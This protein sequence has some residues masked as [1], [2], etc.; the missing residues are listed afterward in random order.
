MQIKLENIGKSFGKNDV[1]KGLDLTIN[2]GELISLVGP[3]GC[4]KSTTL[5][6]LS[7]LEDLSSG[8]IY[9]DD[10][11]V[12]DI[13]VEARNVGLVFQ[14]YALYPHLSVYKNIE[15]PL[16]NDKKISSEDRAL[17]VKDAIKSVG[18][19][20]HVQKKPGQLSGGQA[21]RVAIARAIVKKPNVLLLDE[22]LSNLDAKL[23]VST[24][25]EIKR[26]QR[27]HNITTV[28]VTHDQQEALAISD[29]MV[30]LNDG[31]IQ[32]V[33]KPNDLYRNPSNLFV[34]KFIGSP[35]INYFECE[36]VNKK[37]VGFEDLC[38]DA[39]EITDG[40]YICAIRPEA[41]HVDS[42]SLFCIKNS[43]ILGR[44]ILMHGDINGLDIRILVKNTNSIYKE[45]VDQLFVKVS[46]NDILFFDIN[47]QER[48][49]Y[50]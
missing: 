28:F 2:S 44:D 11:D 36:V 48:V 35:S 20:D 29:R 27:E 30:V 1:I 7:G 9:F 47:T 22:P 12:T 39:F 18:L 5:F 41:F 13:S 14:N 6:I 32:Q 33:G 15:F 42:G 4:G 50:E 34:A 40:K 45:D 24:I 37:I 3:S 23:K 16:T 25:M 21:Q 17:R 31:V 26:I 38:T 43:E 8:S 49:T 10:K 19:E 46:K